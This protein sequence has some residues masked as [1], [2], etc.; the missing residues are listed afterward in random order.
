LGTLA[1]ENTA[2]DQL[3]QHRLK[4][5]KY[6]PLNGVAF[7]N[8]MLAALTQMTGDF[9]VACDLMREMLGVSVRIMPVTTHNTHICAELEDGTMI[10]QEVNVRALGKPPIK[11]VFIQD[12]M[13]RAYKPCLEA[14]NEADLITI[15]PGSLF[16]TV[17]ACLAFDELSEAI[18][19]S[20]ATTV[21][22]CNNTTQPGQTDGY[23]LHDHVS[24]ISKYLNGRLDYV[25]I[26]SRTPSPALRAAYAKDGVQVLLPTNEEIERIE[27]LG[28]KVYAR[29][30]AQMTD[31]KRDLYDKQDSIRHDPEAVAKVLMELIE[32]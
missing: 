26:N 27:N 2:F 23:G 19:T 7:G 32:H 20:R 1:G 18:Q 13:A 10:E 21:Y 25:L 5:P 8:L 4:V 9:G 14:I 28:V 30:L 22:V 24:Q 15:G 6:E 16:T 17:L 12:R 3:I 29:D 31:A 11:R